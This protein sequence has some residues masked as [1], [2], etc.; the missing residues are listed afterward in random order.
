MME[1]GLYEGAWTWS[2]CK[3]SSWVLAPCGCCLKLTVILFRR[4]VAFLGLSMH[5]IGICS[6]K[7]ISL[8]KFRK[9]GFLKTGEVLQSGH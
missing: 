4:F 5:L 1:F 3:R 6:L 2:R 7:P 8:S 9:C